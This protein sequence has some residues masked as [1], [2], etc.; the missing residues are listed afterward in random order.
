MREHL[1]AAFAAMREYL[2][3]DGRSRHEVLAWNPR[4]DVTR[5]FDAGAEA[6]L[7]DYFRRE[8]D[9]P[10]R[11][12]TEEQG[13]ARSRPGRAQWTL[14]VDPVDGSENFARGNEFTSIALALVPGEAA[15]IRPDAVTHALVGNVF[16][17][18]L[19]EAVRGEGAWRGAESIR[20]S[21]VMVLAEALV[22]TDSFKDKTALARVGAILS[23]AKDLRRFGSAAGEL[24]LVAS[25]GLDAY[26]DVRDT[27]SPE[28]YM[29]PQLLL[30]EAG[31]VVSDRFGR[32]LAPVRS[33]TQG[34]SVVAAATPA[35]HAEILAALA[36]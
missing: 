13:E 32:P 6:L 14:V 26:V 29:A 21:T 22:G 19:W 27:L 23:K 9:A 16:T 17:G 34:Q 12:M 31:A 2:L 35:L 18:T 8:V 33:M 36:T 1:R 30:C 24:A 10:V 4:G 11:F 25:G 3:G 5:A 28:N 15:E 7:I 20:P